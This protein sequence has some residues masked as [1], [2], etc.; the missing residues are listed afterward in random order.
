VDLLDEGDAAALRDYLRQNP[1]LPGQHVR[2]EGANYF[3]NPALLG[4]FAKNSIRHGT[5]PANIAEVATVILEAGANQD[6]AA[7]NETAGVERLVAGADSE[8]RHRALAL[9][10]QFG[11]AGIVRLL[12]DAGGD[13]SRYNPGNCHSHSTPL[14][15]VERGARV[16]A[17]AT[18]WPATPT[19]WAKHGG[20]GEIEFYLAGR[21]ISPSPE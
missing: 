17:K 11:H 7:V 3:Q 10:A 12:L 13:P 4:F 6:S 16:D 14:H 19:M 2:F 18:M 15:Q 20:H 5:L 21:T 1:D 9:A 8:E